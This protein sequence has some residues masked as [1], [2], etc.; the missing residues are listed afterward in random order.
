[1]K[2]TLPL[3]LL[4]CAALSESGLR[5]ATKYWDI[6][7]ATP[8]AG[9]ATPAGTWN[10]GGLA[11]WTTSSTGS[12]AGTT[13]A[14]GDDAV[15]SAGTDATGVFAVTLDA[16]AS[17]PVQNAGNLTVEEG[18]VTI[19]GG[20]LL[21]LNVGG[22]TAGKGIIN[23][24]GSATAAIAAPLD[25]TY[26]S[27][28]DDTGIL[29][30]TGTGTLTLSSNSF[31]G[32][33]VVI[34]EGVL[35]V[36]DLACLGSTLAPTI[37]SNGA[38]LVITTNNASATAFRNEPLYVNG[39]GFGNGGAV[40][41]IAGCRI[42]GSSGVTLDS[43][44]RLYSVFGEFRY[45]VF[46][47]D[48]NFDCTFAG[49]GNHRLNV[50]GGFK[51][52]TGK[53]I[54]EGA[55]Y[56]Q[57]EGVTYTCGEVDFKDGIFRFRELPGGGFRDAANVDLV[58]F[59][60]GVDADEFRTVLAN[61]ITVA[62]N[63]T[64]NATNLLVTLVSNSQITLPGVISGATG[65]LAKG[66][67]PASALVLGGANTYGGNT[68]VQGGVLTLGA[69]GSISNSAAIDVWA[70]AVFD[71]ST[72]VNPFVLGSSQTLK[73]NG[74]VA[75]NITAN[76][77]VSPGA[78]IGSLLFSNS[79][80]VSKLLIEVDKSVSPSND[81]IKVIGALSAGS[82]TLTVNNLGPTLAVGDTFYVFT[83][84]VGNPKVVSGGG[85]LIVSGG[86][87]NWTNQLTANGSIKVLSVSVTPPPVPATN[88][89][90]NAVGPNSVGLGGKGAAN[91]AYDV[92]A[93]T[94]VAAAMSNWWKIGTTNSSAGGVI[95][96]VDSQATNAY[97][98][99]RF[100]QPSP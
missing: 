83:D 15:F 74:A 16:A 30:K 94:N 37:V 2:P 26:G 12:A 97:R 7:G 35:A 65:G 14:S 91:A 57:T 90:V 39:Q 13:W 38:T 73:G 71:V 77:T 24:A 75:G 99:Y 47:P 81:V 54:K 27:L 19:V 76:G 80:T 82:G 28:G 78:S 89:T 5:A 29:T 98:F 31:Y 85:S 44:S 10:T 67:N 51:L 69:N 92:Y 49:D 61:N 86:G 68:T 66:T 34:A 55:G 17:P 64:L 32:T 22:G 1:M 21:Y 40:R 58:P 93:Y 8:G 3:T 4:I 63:L 9:G 33:T 6:D 25:D 56:V 45:D 52:G 41:S 79:L 59:T 11:N 20:D 100:G 42:G 48:R 53:L 23:V 36:T 88:L 95:Q 60:V 18:I 46:A 50:N 84:D 43:A 62:N 96:F 70:G 72:N 87:A